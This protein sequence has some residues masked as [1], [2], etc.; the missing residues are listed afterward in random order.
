M[1]QTGETMFELP[2]YLNLAKQINASLHGK[3]VDQGSLGNTPHKFI[4]YNR[5]PEEFAALT[6][7]RSIGEAYARGKWLFIPLEP[8][9]LLVFGECGGRLLFHPPPAQPPSK[10]HLYLAFEDSAG[11]S[12][13][14]Q[15]WGA[16]ELYEQG[17]ESTRQYLCDMRPVPL[18]PEFTLV[19]FSALIAELAQGQKRSVKSLL[20]QDQLV[21]GLGNACAQDILF[22]AKLDPRH[23]IANLS[24]TQVAQLYHSIIE[25]LQA[26][27]AG[28]GRYDEVDLYNQPGGYTR[29]MDKHAAGHPCPECG[30]K[31]VKI[32]YLGGACYFCPHCQ[33]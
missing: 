2:E 3:V 10:Y 20:T 16:M 19:H 21:P 28:G 9:Y 29:L 18:E 31:V 11:F 25:T 4:W 6:R 17:Q 33:A 30:V 23:P 7:G 26:I 13:F 1:I 8:E 15:M 5:T 27:I 12:A 24:V 32:Q 14:T 22:H